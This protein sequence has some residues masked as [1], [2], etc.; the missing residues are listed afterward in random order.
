M[1]ADPI[2]P[3]L[4][5]LSDAHALGNAMEMHANTDSISDVADEGVND[6]LRD[7][8]SLKSRTVALRSVEFTRRSHSMALLNA[9][10][11]AALYTS[12]A[13]D[14]GATKTLLDA[15]ARQG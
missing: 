9:R 13:R 10:V 4:A 15:F 11:D 14:D 12:L 5:L 7:I 8:L 6:A 2:S 3:A 1:P